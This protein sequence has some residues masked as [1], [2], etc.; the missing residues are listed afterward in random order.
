MYYVNLTILII[1]DY[2]LSLF[3]PFELRKHW[4]M[5]S[6]SIRSFDVLYL[7]I[8]WNVLDGWG[9]LHLV[10]TILFQRLAD[11]IT[12]GEISL[13]RCEQWF[14]VRFSNRF[15]SHR[16]INIVDWNYSNT[17]S[18]ASIVS[19]KITQIFHVYQFWRLSIRG[20]FYTK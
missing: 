15:I 14:I 2:L 20:T 1:T 5:A 10:E 13:N 6:V 11:I 16:T 19:A 7:M 3:F 12:R 17:Y 9:V 4:Q 18:T 8:D